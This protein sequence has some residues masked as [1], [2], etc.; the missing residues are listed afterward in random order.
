MTMTEILLAVLCGICALG[1]LVSVQKSK[2]VL[3]DAEELLD[4]VSKATAHKVEEHRSTSEAF[5]M[6]DSKVDRIAD[7]CSYL[8][9]EHDH[10][11]AV[12]LEH[13]QTEGEE[14]HA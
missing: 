1:A 13:I 8:K 7:K 9:R 2:E 11:R 14:K 4:R 5:S 12:V 6:L 10:L 3:R